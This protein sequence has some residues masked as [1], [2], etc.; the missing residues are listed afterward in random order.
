M[1]LQ[2]IPNGLYLSAI[3]NDAYPIRT[4]YTMLSSSH[5]FS[6][7]EPL[8]TTLSASP[9]CFLVLT[10]RLLN[11][12]L[13]VDENVNPCVCLFRL[14]VV[15]NQASPSLLLLLEISLMIADCHWRGS[16]EEERRFRWR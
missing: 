13:N 3:A 14:I 5:V 4:Y 6:P 12:D 10:S 16:D 2:D 11:L 1:I 9:T 7:S 8:Y 15:G